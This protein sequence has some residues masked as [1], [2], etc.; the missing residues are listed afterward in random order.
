METK[1]EPPAMRWTDEQ[2]E[3]FYDYHEPDREYYDGLMEEIR[4][5][6][7]ETHSSFNKCSG[8]W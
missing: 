7:A 3:H 5:R 4:N 8:S 2:W 6:C 1:Q